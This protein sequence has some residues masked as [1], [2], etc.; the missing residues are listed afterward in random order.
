MATSVISKASNLTTSNRNGVPAVDHHTDD[1]LL[2]ELRMLVSLLPERVRS[3]LEVHPDMSKLVEVVMD[4]G[5]PPL[6]RFPDREVELS[7]NPVTAE[8][9]Q[10]AVEQVGDFDDDNRS[11]IDQTLHRISCIRNRAGRIVGLTCRAGRAIDGS[12]ALIEDFVKHGRNVLLLGKPGVGKTTAIRDIS[13]MLA[14]AMAK[15]TVIVD[16]SNEIGGDG[17]VPHPGIG[18]ARR[19]QVPR[20]EEQHRV[21]QEAVENHMPQAIIIDEIGTEAECQAARTIAQRGVQLVA[22]AHGN[23]L[24]NVIKNPALNL[25]VGGIQSVTLGDEAAK[26]RGVQKSILERA[27]P[28]TFDVC[29]EMVERNCWRIHGNVGLAVD[30]ILAGREASSMMR[31]RDA[32]TGAI[33]DIAFKGIVRRVDQCGEMQSM[34]LWVASDGEEILRVTSTDSK[35]RISGLDEVVTQRNPSLTS[36]PGTPTP[37]AASDT[38]SSP[39][40]FLRQ[41]DGSN[42]TRRPLPSMLV[43]PAES[44][45]S[46]VIVSRGSPSVGTPASTP[47]SKGLQPGSTGDHDTNVDN[48]SDE[49]VTGTLTPGSEN[50]SLGALGPLDDTPWKL[51]WDAGKVLTTSLGGISA[52]LD[53]DI[54]VSAAGQEQVGVDGSSSNEYQPPLWPQPAAAAAVQPTS[55]PSPPAPTTPGAATAGGKKPDA[56]PHHE[57]GLPSSLGLSASA[58]TSYSAESSSAPVA[59]GTGPVTPPQAKRPEGTTFRVYLFMD[60]GSADKVQQVLGSLSTATAVIITQEL[61]GAQVV[62]ATSSKLRSSPRMKSV[63]RKLN[64]PIHTIRSTSA[65]SIYRDLC[66]LLG[67]NPLTASLPP[68]M[69]AASMDSGSVSSDDSMDEDLAGEE[70]V[71]GG[72]TTQEPQ[73]RDRDRSMPLGGQGRAALTSADDYADLMD[74][75]VRELRYAPVDR[76]YSAQILTSF[77]SELDGADTFM[78]SDHTST[79]NSCRASS[80]STMAWALSHTKHKR[81]FVAANESALRQLASECESRW[82]EFTSRD[83]QRLAQGMSGLKIALWATWVEEITSRCRAAIAQGEYSIEQVERISLALYNMESLLPPTTESHTQHSTDVNKDPES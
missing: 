64:V 76:E 41:Q 54:P 67:I 5:R 3:I 10:Q 71:P 31:D 38:L 79:V 74:S 42:L 46:S 36:A 13:R 81:K 61:T 40:R 2:K 77:L 78:P 23:A 21:M 26:K 52:E 25:L 75:T 72:G 83:L 12:A 73:A 55:L 53:N 33:R 63:V 28:P 58:F 47:S 16:T 22:T 4:L 11:G 60:D 50:D 34:E 1:L 20:P 59:A 27:A 65:S 48:A 70:R 6:A 43:V 66:P 14:N 30:S 15:R 9:L 32:S 57:A 51:G 18:D 45:E 29:V 68:S 17:D 56:A 35:S 39:G 49:F 82:D 8:D 69:A 44:S 19:M 24:E 7:P 80:L 37:V 62:V